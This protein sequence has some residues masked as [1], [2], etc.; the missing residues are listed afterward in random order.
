MKLYLDNCCFNRPFDDQTKILVYL[1]TRAV[2]TI[3]ENIIAGN[4]YLVWS[5]ILTYENAQNPREFPRQEIKRW[6]NIAVKP[7]IEESPAL[8]EVA[9]KLMQTGIKM[10][11]ALHVSS[12]I[13]GN[14]NYFITTNKKLLNKLKSY[15]EIIALDPIAFIK[16]KLADEK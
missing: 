15:K 2:I 7:I 3:Q 12:A 13:M 11:D 8:L 4:Y 1:E 16:E 5:Y 9:N 10:K 14:C 6:K